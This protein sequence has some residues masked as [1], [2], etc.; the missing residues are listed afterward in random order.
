MTHMSSRRLLPLAAATLLLASFSA[1]QSSVPDSASDAK[2]LTVGTKAPSAKLKGIDGN[3]LKLKDVIAG[4]PTVLIFYRGDWCPFCNAHLAD[5]GKVEGEL[6]SLGYQ[7][8]AISPDTPS[9]LKK[10]IGKH[11]LDYTFLSD[12]SAKALKKY[13]VAYRLDDK[14]Y[15][16]MKEKYNEDIERS[17]G[18]THHLLPVPSVF[19]IDKDGKIVFVHSNPDF[20]VRMKGEE[21]VAAAK[22]A[23]PKM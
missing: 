11:N 22:E 4:K 7:I 17:S 12:S 8:V 6:K 15:S 10:T 9:E 21:I 3:E 20:K 2:P 5:L 14:T 23:T 18:E 13:G 1:A 16:L 19:L